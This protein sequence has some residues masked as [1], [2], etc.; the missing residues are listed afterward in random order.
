MGHI[1]HEIAS[2]LLQAQQLALVQQGNREQFVRVCL[3][4]I[5]DMRLRMPLFGEAEGNLA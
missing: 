3:A 2:H 4:E 1:R 5:P